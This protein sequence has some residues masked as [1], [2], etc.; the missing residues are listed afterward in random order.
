MFQKT[1]GIILKEKKIGEADKNLIIYAYHLGKI[2][3]LAK[4]VDRIYSKK[5]RHLQPFSICQLELRKNKKW[6][7]L[8]EVK[9]IKNFRKIK[10]NLAK[11]MVGYYFNELLDKSLHGEERNEE[12][13]NLFKDS[14]EILNDI[15]KDKIINLIYAFQIKLIKILG[16]LFSFQNENDLYEQTKINFTHQEF[17]ILKFLEEKELFQSIRI[18]IKKSKNIEKLLSQ[19][20]E[21]ILNEEVNSFKTIKKVK[22]FHQN[23]ACF[24]G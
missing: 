14:L 1:E 11:T 20:W 19:L 24:K 13:F 21:K 10:D 17:I 7:Y 12:I 2:N 6:F 23:Y 8:R 3:V 15:K 5:G 16:Y 9:I 18:K 22:K 4:G